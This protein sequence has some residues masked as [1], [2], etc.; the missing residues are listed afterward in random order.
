MM[1]YLQRQKKSA[2]SNTGFKRRCYLLAA[3]LFLLSV[4]HSLAVV[5]DVP[6]AGDIEI[7]AG[8]QQLA[9]AS[10]QTFSK[11]S[12]Q[13]N[14]QQVR[15]LVW[16]IVVGLFLLPVLLLAYYGEGKRRQQELIPR[17]LQIVRY[18]NRSD[19]KKEGITF[20]IK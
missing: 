6:V 5:E 13:R 20:S 16:Y 8:T 18:R 9:E 12:M 19:G 2:T 10:L 4:M 17:S 14:E 11:P 3:I 1:R 7:R 15:L